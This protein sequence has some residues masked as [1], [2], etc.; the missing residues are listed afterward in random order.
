MAVDTTSKA[1]ART[2]T[3]PRRV[4]RLRGGDRVLVIVMVAIPTILVVGLVWGSAL[5][6]MVLSFTNWDG[7]GG[8]GTIKFVGF[9]NY[10][11]VAT[12][13]PPFKPAIEH[14]LLWLAFLFLIPTIFG[15]F[16]AVLLDK[17]IRGSRFYQ[18]ALYLPIVLSLAL[19]GF[20]WQLLYSQDQGLLNAVLGT[21]VDWYG[22]P[23]VNI[24]AVLV[25]SAWKHTG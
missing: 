7:I 1:G 25:A 14:N 18:T 23:K 9:K 5:I 19:T 15:M 21:N 6:T 12:I 24:W 13:Y 3:R 22:D 11:D 16:L 10:H 20:I 8:L 17:E 4:K 2:R